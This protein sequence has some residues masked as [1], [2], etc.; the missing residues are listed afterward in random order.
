MRIFNNLR[1][2]LIIVAATTGFGGMVIAQPVSSIQPK[3]NETLSETFN[4]AFFANDPDFFRNR[5]FKRQLEW[6]FGANGFI[7][8]EIARDAEDVD[9][10]YEG[11]LEKQAASDPTIRTRDLPNPY[12]TSILASP[13]IDVNS[14][15]P[16][17]EVIFEQR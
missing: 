2:G 11:A 12:E 9:N 14:R 16:N 15:T 1:V 4:Q 17:D 3:A 5:S 8:N 13:E 7:E 10:L 6:M